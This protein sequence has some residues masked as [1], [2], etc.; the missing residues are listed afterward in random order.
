[1]IKYEDH[2][3]NS[4]LFQTESEKI[5]IYSVTDSRIIQV[6]KITNLWEQNKGIYLQTKLRYVL[7]D[8]IK[9]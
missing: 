1:M 9:K 3:T 6:H 7:L 5:I 2:I 4:L 8:I